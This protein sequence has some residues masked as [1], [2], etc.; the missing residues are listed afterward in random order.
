MTG[1]GERGAI[2]RQ[3]AVRLW[4]VI[5]NFLASEVGGRAI[6]MGV[7]LLLLLVAINGTA[8]TS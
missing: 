6:A 2:G 3:M 4:R 1:S 8:S 5:R 7:G